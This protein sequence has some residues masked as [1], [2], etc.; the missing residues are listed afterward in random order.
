MYSANPQ[1][2]YTVCWCSP[3]TSLY[4]C[5]RQYGA[6]SNG[7]LAVRTNKGFIECTGARPPELC[8]QCLC[9]RAETC[10]NE[11]ACT[12][13]RCESTR[14]LCFCVRLYGASS[15]GLCAVRAHKSFIQ[16]ADACPLGLCTQCLFSRAGACADELVYKNLYICTLRAHKFY[17]LLCGRVC[18]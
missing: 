15:K 11:R 2:L 8:T 9:A 12:S 16:C 3:T 4:F 17:V 1:G 7:L 10:A 13:V 6:S 18:R 5:V 14:A